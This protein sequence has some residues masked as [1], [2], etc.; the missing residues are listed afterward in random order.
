VAVVGYAGLF[1]VALG[2]TSSGLAPVELLDAWTLG[3]LLAAALLAASAVAAVTAHRRH[4]PSP[5]E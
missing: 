2:R 1:G 4:A 3:Y 5:K